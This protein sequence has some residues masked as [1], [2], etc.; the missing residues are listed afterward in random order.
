VRLAGLRELVERV[1]GVDEVHAYKPDPRPYGL[2]LDAVGG[3]ATL[4]AVHAWDVVGAA[5]GGMR[6]LWVDR[7]ERTWPF[8]LELAPHGTAPD[9]AAAAR[10]AAGR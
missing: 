8:P 7:Q 1:F 3:E 6:V 10:M 5:R 9:L 4:V 2:V